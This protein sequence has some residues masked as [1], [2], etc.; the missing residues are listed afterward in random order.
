MFDDGDRAGAPH[1]G[2]ISASLAKTRW[3]N[4][5][6]IGKVL[7]FG[8]MDGDLTPITIVGVVG[9]VREARLD[10]S[11]DAAVYVDY[12]QRPRYASMFSVVMATTTP[13]SVMNQVRAAVQRLRP[14]LPVRMST[15][16]SLVGASLAQQRFMLLL[17]GVFGAIALLLAS[18]GVYSVISYLV[19]LRS[20]E[21]SIRVALGAAAHDVVRLVLGQGL[22][23][24][25]TGAVLGAVGAV[26]VTRLLKTVL[27]EVSPTD[28]VAFGAVLALLAVV[29]VVASYLPARRAARVDP[30]D[31]LRAS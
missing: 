10:A 22:S 15:V 18:L 29:A 11:P 17:V 30:M 2:L 5:D 12:R 13:A 31:V 3:P 4:E 1:V 9:D 14:D 24:A 28:P 16:E 20:H 8:N 21:L 26:A 6:P 23:L 19:A 25:L 27:Y 7:E